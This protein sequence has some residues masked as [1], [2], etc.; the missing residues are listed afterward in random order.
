M[1]STVL[2][3]VVQRPASAREEACRVIPHYLNPRDVQ[4]QPP[5]ITLFYGEKAC[6]TDWIRDPQWTGMLTVLGYHGG[7]SSSCYGIRIET[8]SLY[9]ATTA[10]RG[11]FDPSLVGTLIPDG[12]TPV[13]G[14]MSCLSFMD[15]IPHLRDG[16][17]F[18]T[19]KARKQG[20]NY[21]INRV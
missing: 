19:W 17:A 5:F 3:P 1:A 12:Q 8:G 6:P 2:I 20:Q 13:V 21:M 4:A 11:R 9:S 15:V 10:P 18:G 16:K 7:R 14:M